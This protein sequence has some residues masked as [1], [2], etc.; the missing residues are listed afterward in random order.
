MFSSTKTVGPSHAVTNLEFFSKSRGKT[1]VPTRA[2]IVKV[3]TRTVRAPPKPG[4]VP[5]KPGAAP[6]RPS[7]AAP[8]P[9][10]VASTSSLKSAPSASSSKLAPSKGGPSKNAPTKN[11]PTKKRKSPDAAPALPKQVKRIRN[12]DRPRKRVATPSSSRRSSPSLS[13][14]PVFRNSKSRSTSAIASEDGPPPNTKRQFRTDMDGAPGQSNRSSEK[15]VESLVKSYKPFFDEFGQYTKNYPRVELEYPNNNAT[16]TFILLCPKDLDHYNPVKDAY[17]SLLVIISIL[18]RDQQ[19][20]FG[21]LPGDILSN[22]ASLTASPESSSGSSTLSSPPSSQASANSSLT[23]LSQDSR[24]SLSTPCLSEAA[25]AALERANDDVLRCIQRALN[26]ENGA[27]FIEYFEEANRR[28]RDLKYPMLPADPFVDAPPNPFLEAIEGWSAS[29][30]IPPK[31]LHRIMEENYQR[32]VGP[33]VRELH[34]YEP[35]TDNVYG[36]LMPSLVYEMVRHTRLN[37]NSLFLDLGSGVGNVVVQASLQTGCRSYGIEC[38]EAPAKI[39]AR[40]LPQFKARCRMWG[41]NM[42]DVEL[43]QGDMLTSKRVDELIP[44]ADVVLVNNKVFS[45]SLNEAL[46]PKFLDLKEG[47]IVISLKSFVSEK[48]NSRLT[49][50]NVDDISTIFDVSKR[51]FASGSVSWADSGGE[52]YIHRVDR[53]GYSQILEEY[54]SRRS[55]S[56]S[57]RKTRAPY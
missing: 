31:V 19:R 14:E 30:G 55:S 10:P 26:N 25:A 28:L 23:A 33:F 2:P 13:P 4:A 39:A 38:Q 44:Q 20:I 57:T 18:P 51:W 46:R 47:A 16:E 45:E 37:E 11:A 56:R 6:P 43:E 17:D 52:Y 49:E 53:R 24:N 7:A 40:M 29:G 5:P 1:T 9:N 21:V 27:L 48:Q 8:K 12:E 22:I 42:G 34:Q 32:N 3:T 41:V 54:E 50:R 36:E 35:F 15:V